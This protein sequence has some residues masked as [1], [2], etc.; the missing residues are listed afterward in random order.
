MIKTEGPIVRLFLVRHG[1][2]AENLQMHYIGIRD[3]PLTDRGLQQA[4]QAA[5]ALAQI[6]IRIVLTSPLRRAADTAGEI[7]E[8]CGVELR[9]D[10]RLAEGSFGSWEG[11][12]RD[13][14]LNLSRE[15]A[16][17]LAQWES[18]PSCAPP[19]GE[20][21][22]KVQKRIISLAQQ[23]ES[24]FPNSSVVLVSHVGPI[25]AIIAAALDMPLQISRHLFLDPCTISVVDW[26][27][28]PLLR[29]FNS[30]AHMGWTSARW[31]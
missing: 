20:S 26:G 3:E 28:R 15:D 30:H 7:Q 21:F 18:D 12:N 23:L 10:S 13:E 19:G 11:L 5:K 25:K 22:E 9:M 8:S 6:P 1:V 16:K 24:E 17:L 2:T 14:V 4:R 27:K 29:L 31:M